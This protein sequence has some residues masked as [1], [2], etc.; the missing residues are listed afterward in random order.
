MLWQLARRYAGRSFPDPCKDPVLAPQA[1]T[2]P[3]TGTAAATVTHKFKT[4]VYT[5]QSY[6][7]EVLPANLDEVAPLFKNYLDVI[8]T[9]LPL[10]ASPRQI[11]WRS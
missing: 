2:Q 8:R 4:S 7:T 9:S 6:D 11:N 10:S 3:N 5:E 1:P